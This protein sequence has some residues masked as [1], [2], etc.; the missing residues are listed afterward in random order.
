MTGWRVPRQSLP[1]QFAGGILT[2]W[3]A[4]GTNDSEIA[5]GAGANAGYTTTRGMLMKGFTN[6][7]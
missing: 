7:G 4:T 6:D 5:P 1:G 3:P 2:V